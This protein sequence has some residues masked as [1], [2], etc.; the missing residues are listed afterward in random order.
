M[1]IREGPLRAAAATA[2]LLGVVALVMPALGQPMAQ[3][4]PVTET[5]LAWLG[6]WELTAVGD[7]RSQESPDSL[8]RICVAP[9]D[10]PEVLDLT[11]LVNDE[12]VAAQTLVTDGSRQPVTDG[13]CDGWKRSVLSEDRRRLYLQSEMACEDGKPRSLTGA[14]ILVS[15]DH[16][17]DIH[18][19]RIDGER[20]IVIQHFRLVGAEFARLPGAFPTTMHTVRVAAAAPLTVEDVIEALEFVDPAVVEAMLL[21]S[22]A[23]FGIDS[24]LLLRLD[25]ANVPGEVI[26]LMVALS[27]PEYFAVEGDTVGRRPAEYYS[28]YW[29]PWYPFHGYGYGH[30]YWYYHHRPHPPSG[31]HPGKDHG[32][33]VISGRGYVGVRQTSNPSGIGGFLGV[34]GDGGGGGSFGTGGGG[35][36]GTGSGGSGSSASSSGFK[37]GNSSSVR[38]AVPKPQ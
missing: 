23:S 11:A 36:S 7:S 38:P 27:F 26:D 25:D 8:Q 6:C 34:D 16:W 14:S 33:S 28:S 20:E 31:G 18:V 1:S 5:A 32:G 12:I 3:E 17:V 29:S 30:G 22:E 2:C 9:G 15:G 13:D 10:A 24:D 35:I 21:E 4:D 37:G 19:S